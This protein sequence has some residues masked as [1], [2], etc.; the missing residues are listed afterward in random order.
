MSHFRENK[1]MK[2]DI[3]LREFVHLKSSGGIHRNIITIIPTF[4]Y[5]QKSQNSINLNE[6]LKESARIPQEQE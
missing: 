4:N 1:D 2:L 5:Q 6:W 3:V